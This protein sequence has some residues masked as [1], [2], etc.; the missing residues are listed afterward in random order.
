MPQLLPSWSTWWISASAAKFRAY[1]GGA[2]PPKCDRS[3]QGGAQ[4]LLAAGSAEGRPK[5][6]RASQGAHPR[7]ALQTGKAERGLVLPS[8]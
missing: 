3:V 1:I 8:D 6:A 4:G 5:N 2:K 7:L